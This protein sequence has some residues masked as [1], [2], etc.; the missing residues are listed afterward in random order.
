MSLLTPI[1]GLVA[2]TEE[3]VGR[4]L[5]S[6]QQV[7][8]RPHRRASW[9]PCPFRVAGADGVRHLLALR[10]LCC[11]SAKPA[12]P[13]PAS[14]QS[15]N[16]WRHSLPVV[17]GCGDSN[18]CDREVE[19]PH[20]NADGCGHSDPKCEL[21]LIA[22]AFNSLPILIV[23]AALTGLSAALGNRGNLQVANEI[24]PDDKRAEVLSSYLLVIS[25][26]PYR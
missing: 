17:S 22:Q 18:A 26:I 10:F 13:R 25:A 14:A 20:G 19:K 16:C 23:G 21:L 11:A 6:L 24:A 4:R 12:Q 1:V 7:S 8:L 3:T 2:R 5:H 9:H 15:C